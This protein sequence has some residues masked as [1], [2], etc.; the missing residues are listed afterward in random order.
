[1][2]QN[3]D[4]PSAAAKR[5]MAGAKIV[6]IL[7]L[8]PN[9][10]K[11]PMGTWGMVENGEKQQ[12]ILLSHTQSYL[13]S[14]HTNLLHCLLFPGV[15]MKNARLAINPESYA[16]YQKE[17]ANKVTVAASNKAAKKTPLASRAPLPAPPPAPPRSVQ[18]TE[19]ARKLLTQQ[20][21]KLVSVAIKEKDSSLTKRKC[22]ETLALVFG[23]KR[24]EE[25]KE[26]IANE[27][28]RL[29][30]D[31]RKME[32]KALGELVEGCRGV[33]SEEVKALGEDHA[34]D[35]F[36][37]AQIGVNRQEVDDLLSSK[38]L[39]S[40]RPPTSLD[41]EMEEFEHSF[42]AEPKEAGAASRKRICKDPP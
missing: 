18:V 33:T 14:L 11:H 24:V 29:V 27:V 6:H 35:A 7:P 15:L 19:Q 23:E 40:K 22:R 1:M 39:L 31:Y 34:T 4:K 16:S 12:I 36:E 28:V 13:L 42:F 8:Q 32:E 3:I 38:D 10:G 2:E 20:I 41:E 37:D 17:Q 26:H 25:H 9:D 5:A 21:E 30:A